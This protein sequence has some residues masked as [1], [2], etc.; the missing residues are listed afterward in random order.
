MRK[1]RFF[2]SGLILAMSFAI[3]TG[4]GKKTE[5]VVIDEMVVEDAQEEIIVEEAV[6][7]DTVEEPEEKEVEI[8]EPDAVTVQSGE[9]KYA[10]VLEQYRY[11]INNYEDIE[12]EVGDGLFGMAESIMY[13]GAEAIGYTFIDVNGDGEDELIFANIN[14]LEPGYGIGE[15]STVYAMW[16]FVDDKPQLVFESFRRSYYT[17][18]NGNKFLY[19]GSNGAMY[20]GYGIYSFE[21]GA[22]GLKAE[23]FYFTDDIS[24]DTDGT[25]YYL[26]RQGDWDRE[27]AEPI[28]E[29]QFWDE[30]DRAC[31]DM[32]VI[33]LQ[34][35]IDRGMYGVG[36]DYAWKIYDNYDQFE[37]CTVDDGEYSNIIAVYTTEDTIKGVTVFKLS[38]ED[39]DNNGN[40]LFGAEEIYKFE[41]FDMENPLIL[42]IDFPG[43]TPSYGLS[44]TDKDGNE[45]NIGISLS[46][47]DGIPVMSD[48][49]IR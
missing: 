37:T 29:D 22:E 8:I 18:L 41:K 20:T 6:M 27:G 21:S 43:D 13:G 49:I 48:I 2:I 31:E 33:K 46:G 15:F 19:I 16:S 28:E 3:F 44:F 42:K 30:Y 4:C 23:E 14:N 36:A 34:Y 35:V 40:G 17:L 7:E 38:F 25:G 11:Y 12:V 32:A 45:R 1:T 47:R 9:E 5:D 24:E 26:N 39:V 10:D